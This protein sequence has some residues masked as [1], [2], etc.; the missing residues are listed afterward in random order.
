MA[1]IICNTTPTDM[2]T[3]LTFGPTGHLT[4]LLLG[5]YGPQ[6]HQWNLNFSPPVL[7]L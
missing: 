4:L 2:H 1:K 6:A 3:A 5:L 7:V